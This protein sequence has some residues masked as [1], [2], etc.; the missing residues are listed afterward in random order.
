L[1]T[2]ASTDLFSVRGK[3]ILLTGAAGYLGRTLAEAALANGAR[4]IAISRPGRLEA[5][6]AEWKKEFGDDS[7]VGYP[8]DMYDVEA[9]SAL[10]DRIVN[11]VTFIE[12]IVNNAHEMGLMTGFN[13]PDGTIEEASMDQ[14]MRHLT[15]AAYWPALV[16]QKLG[17]RMRG[18]RKGT[19]IN[20]SSMYAL[21]APTPRLYEGTSFLNPPGYS[22]GKAAML[23]LTRYLASFWGPYGIRANAI[24]PGPFSNSEDLS[25]LNAVRS[26]DPFLD[27]LRARTCLG[28]IGRAEELC[29]PFLFLAS[30]AS[31]YVTG[32]ALSVDGGWTII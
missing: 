2:S 11:D 6:V 27:R 21:V 16:C 3:S 29:G 19:I 23:A 22:A 17:S 26:D 24:L 32:Q 15:A 25:A 13:S 7:V 20:I 8:V 28:R 10:L 12:V 30:D 31:S 1:V 14:W 4:L 5:Q 18:N 9:L